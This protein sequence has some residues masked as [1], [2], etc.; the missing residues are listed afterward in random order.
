M[1]RHCG[2]SRARLAVDAALVLAIGLSAAG[3]SFAPKSFRKVDDAAPIIR[4]RSVS[5]GRSLPSGQVV[6]ALLDRLDDRD[7]VVRLAAYEELHKGTG[8]TFGYVPWAT[9]AERKAAVARW[10]EWWRGRQPGL[11]RTARKR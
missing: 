10:R 6:P 2:N 9:E 5:L 3:C 1:T 4:A 7:P 11:A 8:Q